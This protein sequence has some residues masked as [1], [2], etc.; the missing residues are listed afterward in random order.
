MAQSVQSGLRG[1]IVRETSG[2]EGKRL[3][4]V[5]DSDEAKDATKRNFDERISRI[6]EFAVEHTW[7]VLQAPNISVKVKVKVKL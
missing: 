3:E 1:S 2:G 7:V 4:V 6:D 5:L